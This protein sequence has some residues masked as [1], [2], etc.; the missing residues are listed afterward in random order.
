MRSLL[1]ALS[2]FNRRE[3]HI[4]VGWVLDRLS[5]QLGHE[6]RD[7][8]RRVI[9][10]PVPAD[11]FAAMDYNLN[12]L[13]SA[14]MSSEGQIDVGRPPHQFDPDD[15]IDFGDNSDTDLVVAFAHGT[16][17]HIVL[18]EAK[19]FTKWDPAQIKRKAERLR[20]IFGDSGARFSNVT[21]YWV[22]VSPKPISELA[23]WPKSLVSWMLDGEGKPR[24][25]P[26]PQPSSHKY[27]LLRCDQ[28]G[29]PAENAGYWTIRPD[30]WPGP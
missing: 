27:A 21:P 15:G 30:P 17:T 19:G 6:F 24:H 28:L 7:E 25:L 13:C 20:L 26:L 12:W 22:F 16:K 4:L 14:L 29:Q 9:G 23:Q 3:R 5:F 8:L 10:V 18:L 1:D 2:A 11:A